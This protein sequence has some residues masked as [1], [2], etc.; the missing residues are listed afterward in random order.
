M[1]PIHR[2]KACDRELCSSVADV[3][4]SSLLGVGYESVWRR[5]RI[6]LFVWCLHRHAAGAGVARTAGASLNRNVHGQFRNGFGE[7][8]GGVPGRGDFVRDQACGQV[9]VE[10]FPVVRFVGIVDEVAVDVVDDL[11]ELVVSLGFALAF[12]LLEVQGDVDI[13]DR[14]PLVLDVVVLD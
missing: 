7:F 12:G 8:V 9:G 5:C 14:C 2:F 11:L 13:Q 4:E 10:D 3:S 1:H 6:G